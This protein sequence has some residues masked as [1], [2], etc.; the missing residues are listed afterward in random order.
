M[1][2]S[3]G[4]TSTDAILAGTFRVYGYA[5]GIT[6]EAF[7]QGIGFASVYTLSGRLIAKRTVSGRTDIAVPAGVYAV[8]VGGAVYKVGVK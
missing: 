6:V 4:S 5:G 7:G 1:I 2:K 8:N 3:A